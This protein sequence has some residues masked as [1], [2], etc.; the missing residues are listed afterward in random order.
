MAKELTPEQKAKK[1]ANDK[2]LKQLHKQEAEE[3]V[4]KSKELLAYMKKQGTFD[5][6][7]PDLQDFLTKLANPPVQH[8][9]VSVFSIM[10][11]DNPTVGQTITLMDAF[12]KTMKGKSTIDHFV[13]KKWA[14]AGIIVEFTQDAENMLNS[15]YT[16]KALPDG[17]AT[18]EE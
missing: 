17:V 11:G 2:R 5:T 15:T 13:N 6:L 8:S 1:L 7:T 4:V 3:R 12:Q 10:F 14:P 18:V 16:I 9:T